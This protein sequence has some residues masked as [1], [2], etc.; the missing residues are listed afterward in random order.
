LRL[1]VNLNGDTMDLIFYIAVLLLT[2]AMVG[3]ASGLLG[4][5][6]GFIMVPIQF[7]LLTSMGVDPT[8][9]IRVAFGTSLAVILPTAVS[10]ALGHKRRGAVLTGPMTFMGITG[11]IAAFI[12]GTIASN[13]PGVYLRIIFG[14]LV[15]IAG[16]WM[17][18][19]RYPEIG[20]K[21]KE[22]VLNYLFIGFIAGILSG[23]LGVGGGVVLVPILVL[24]MGFSMYKA[25]GTSTAVIIFTSLGGIFAYTLNGVN[26]TGLPPYS[27]GYIN[28]I[29]FVILVIITVPMAQVGVKASHKLPEKQL[30][31]IF[32][33]VL[34]YIAL[35]MIGVFNW[36]GIPL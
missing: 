35:K 24:I 33:L 27:I 36:V 1:L 26:T 7:F 6:G 15:L 14:F 12:G 30:R 22:G 25:V 2:G 21:P 5:G 11:I 19:A 28:L 31:Y 9:A 18:I 16:M 3:F 23:L 4:V 8:T 32:I 29:Q 13:V 10:G 34:F 20:T 17:L